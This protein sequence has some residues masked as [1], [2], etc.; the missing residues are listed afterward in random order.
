MPVKLR[1]PGSIRVTCSSCSTLTT[2]IC[3]HACIDARKAMMV[4]KTVK[5]V[6]SEVRKP[7]T[8]NTPFQKR[9]QRELQ[10]RAETRQ[11]QN[12][13]LPFHRATKPQNFLD[14]RIQR[15]LSAWI[16]LSQQHPLSHG[17]PHTMATSHQP[18]PSRPY[19]S[20]LTRGGGTGGAGPSTTPYAQTPFNAPQQNPSG[21]AGGFGGTGP[22][23]A[24]TQQQREA[25][26]L[27]RERHERAERERREAE[28]R[29]ALDS[30][31]EEQREEINEAVRSTSNRFYFRRTAS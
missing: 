11:L 7:K 16:A 10:T 30:L 3:T 8:K 19:T 28:E 2:D 14:P 21:A 24:T 12:Y 13:Q 26:R 6:G 27:E 15:T 1:P 17:K 18:F 23:G 20:G 29:A 31:T 4:G 9:K 5:A 25:Q 22:G